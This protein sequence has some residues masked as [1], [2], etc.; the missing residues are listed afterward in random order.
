MVAEITRSSSWNRPDLSFFA[1][2]VSF[3]IIVNDLRDPAPRFD[4][5]VIR[6]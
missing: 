1:S 4:G 2:V 5:A 3:V 6:Q